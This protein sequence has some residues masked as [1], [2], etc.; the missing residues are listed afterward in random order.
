M[1]KKPKLL[2][3]WNFSFTQYLVLLLSLHTN[4]PYNCQPNSSNDLYNLAKGQAFKTCLNTQNN[5]WRKA[6]K[7]C[8]CSD[9]KAEHGMI[10]IKANMSKLKILCGWELIGILQRSRNFQSPSQRDPKTTKVSCSHLGTLQPW[11]KCVHFCV[12]GSGCTGW[13]RCKIHMSFSFRNSPELTQA[14]G[15]SESN[16][17]LLPIRYLFLE[18][19]IQIWRY[20]KKKEL[21]N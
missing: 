19:K 2:H 16:A 15:I 5:H 17:W 11:S 7:S 9:W 14:P 6:T 1:D 21:Q 10:P 18:F 13:Y 20:L 3:L 12:M 4:E 8:H